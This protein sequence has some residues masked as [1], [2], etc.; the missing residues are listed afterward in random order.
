MGQE[1]SK[2]IHRPSNVMIMGLDCTASFEVKDFL[3]LTCNVL[4]CCFCAFKYDDKQKICLEFLCSTKIHCGLGIAE[5]TEVE[6]CD[7]LQKHE[8]NVPTSAT[9]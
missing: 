2:M 9:Y 1:L 5:I 7:L 3:C 4:L 6:I 8:V